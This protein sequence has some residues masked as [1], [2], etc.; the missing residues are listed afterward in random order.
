MSDAEPTTHPSDAVVVG[1]DGSE[2]S[3][4]ALEYALDE[5]A[6]QNRP[7]RAVMAYASPAEMW[8]APA[9][10]LPDARTLHHGAQ[11]A[12]TELVDAATSDRAAR[13]DPMAAT[14]V[15]VYMGPAAAV[16]TRLSRGA[17]LLVVGHRGRS[18]LASHLLGSVGLSCVLHAE[19]TVTVVRG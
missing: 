17:A 19:C 8:T 7:L 3:R 10:L 6:R 14:T 2:G 9:S 12:A 5:A 15:E 18:G 11:K 13:G 1:I 16:L 4:A